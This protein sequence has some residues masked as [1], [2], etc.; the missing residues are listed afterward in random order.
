M[1]NPY[2]WIWRFIR[3]VKLHASCDLKTMDVCLS[4]YALQ[5]RSTRGPGM[6]ICVTRT[7]LLKPAEANRVIYV[8]GKRRTT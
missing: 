4:M 5:R 2:T 8:D 7:L 6:M 3:S 1:L